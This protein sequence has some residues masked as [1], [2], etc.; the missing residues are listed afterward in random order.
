MERRNTGV[1]GGSLSGVCLY[2]YIY[3]YGIW[4]AISHDREGHL[5]P[6]LHKNLDLKYK[7]WLGGSYPGG[8]LNFFLVG[9]CHTGFQK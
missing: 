2:I 1:N 4:H 7:T 9:V 5:F 3:I 6:F 8:A